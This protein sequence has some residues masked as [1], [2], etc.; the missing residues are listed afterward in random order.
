VCAHGS[1]TH[2]PCEQYWPIGHGPA[3]EFTQTPAWQNWFAS[4][5]TFAHGSG[6][7]TNMF[8][9]VSLTQICPSGQPCVRHEPSTHA[10]SLQ[11]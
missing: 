11:M 1:G 10:P 2:W 9:L 3:H 7:Q 5:I 4:H 6:W 8:V